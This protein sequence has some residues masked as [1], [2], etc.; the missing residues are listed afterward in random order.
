MMETKI[1]LDQA[2]EQLRAGTCD[3]EQASKA[4]GVPGLTLKAPVP[5]SQWLYFDRLLQLVGELAADRV[6]DVDLAALQR[7]RPRRLGSASILISLGIVLVGLWRYWRLHAIPHGRGIQ[8]ITFAM[9]VGSIL[10]AMLGG[11]VVA[12]APVEFLKLLLGCVLIVAAVK[13]VTRH[14]NQP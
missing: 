10:G 8:R 13:T 9:S 12:F 14:A 2:R 11:L 1:L 3:R 7:R 6:G 4:R 5:G